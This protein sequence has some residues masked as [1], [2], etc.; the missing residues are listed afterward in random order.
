MNVNS[1]AYLSWLLHSIVNAHRAANYNMHAVVAQQH[2]VA[3][4]WKVY[5]QLSFMFCSV[6]HM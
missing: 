5:N 3:S 2:T 1:T 6:H 4:H